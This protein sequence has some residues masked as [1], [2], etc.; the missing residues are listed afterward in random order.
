MNAKYVKL[1]VVFSCVALCVAA[2]GC[3]KGR[4]FV[5]VTGTVT[6]DG[7]AVEGATVSFVPKVAEGGSS[8]T[9]ITDASGKFELSSG[10]ESGAAP[11]EYY[12]SVAKIETTI[13]ENDNPLLNKVQF[14][15]NELPEQ[16]SDAKSSGLTATVKKGTD[17]I[18]LKLSN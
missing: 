6:L 11:G 1:F 2:S 10:A 4:V 9:G 13:I 15:A 14:G 3:G 8:A 18:E 12:I 5:P 16:Y 17:P 7:E